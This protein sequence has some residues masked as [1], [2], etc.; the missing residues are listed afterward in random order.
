MD[1]RWTP[2][3]G[4]IAPRIRA[5][6]DGDEA[7]AAF[8][9]GKH[10]AGA[11]KI[12]IQRRIVIVVPVPIT[13]GRVAL[14]DLDQGVRYRAGVLVEYASADDDAFA[15]RGGCVLPREIAV[16][17][18]DII[19]AEYRSG[20]FRQGMRQHDERFGRCTLAR[21]RVGGVKIFW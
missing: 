10:A 16:F 7:V 18:P 9:V 3:V 13:S 2:G 11:V 1:M 5:R 14:P 12:R 4:M 17:R 15:Q 8:L 20:H 19:E 6:L 21:G